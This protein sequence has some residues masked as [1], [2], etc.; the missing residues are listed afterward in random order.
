MLILNDMLGNELLRK[1]ISTIEINTEID[2]TNYSAGTYILH[3]TS[4]EGSSIHKIVK[5]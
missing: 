2:L 4:L 3:I 5:Q 1:E